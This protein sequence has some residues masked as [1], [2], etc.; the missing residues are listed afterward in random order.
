MSIGQCIQMVESAGQLKPWRQTVSLVASQAMFGSPPLKGPV[1]IN[2]QFRFA[3]PK[4]HFGTGRNEGT[5]K[6]SAPFVPTGKP[7]LDKLQR[8]VFDALTHIVWLDDA[9]VVEVKA[10]KI[11]AEN[12]GILVLVDEV[13]NLSVAW[14]PQEGV[15]RADT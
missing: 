6:A 2:I 10:Y 9:Q 13:T 3:R 8:A 12:P 4:G 11:Y 5:V 7:D 14:S 1:S 15:L